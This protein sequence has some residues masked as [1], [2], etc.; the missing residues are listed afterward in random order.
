[1]PYANCKFIKHIAEFQSK[2]ERNNVPNNTRGIYIL[3]N[4]SKDNKDKYEVVYIGMSGR[5]TIRG[6][7][8]RLAEHNQNKNKKWTH[9]TVFEVHDNITYAEIKELEGLILC[10]YRKDPRVNKHNAQLRYEPFHD[11][12]VLK[13]NFKKWD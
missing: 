4:Q 13:K 11:P 3:L 8:A 12:K 9:F 7:H 5:S 1:M 2:E 10:I 6:V